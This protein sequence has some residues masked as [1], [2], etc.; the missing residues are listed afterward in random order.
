MQ[1]GKKNLLLLAIILVVGL[2]IGYF[3]GYDHGF[4]KSVGQ[5]TEMIESCKKEAEKQAREDLKPKYGDTVSMEML[6]TSP[7]YKER[8]SQC[9]SE[10]IK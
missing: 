5:N 2:G 7:H 8:Y 3:L 10:K 4:E 1:I 9:L 6:L